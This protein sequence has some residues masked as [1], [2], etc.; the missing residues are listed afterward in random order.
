M[1]ADKTSSYPINSCEHR[2]HVVAATHSKV[3][4]LSLK[5]NLRNLGLTT[6]RIILT[7]P[8]ET[9]VDVVI[10]TGGSS[11]RFFFRISTELQ[12][13][14]MMYWV[15]ISYLYHCRCD[16]A[17]ATCQLMQTI[18]IMCL[19]PW[20]SRTCGRQQ[21]WPRWAIMS[22]IRYYQ[23]IHDTIDRGMCS[24]KTPTHPPKLK[25]VMSHPSDIHYHALS[26]HLLFI[27]LCYKQSMSA[28]IDLYRLSRI[29]GLILNNSS[30]IFIHSLIWQWM[31]DN[32][33][34]EE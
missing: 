23:F 14:E 5:S 1:H 24:A 29:G 2:S 12:N 28:G 19:L 21:R 13:A 31:V 22:V 7:S 11:W 15:C 18:L 10:L 9:L 26:D 4:R 30:I 33:P 16:L 17:S 25:T 8:I 32:L 34:R 27:S 6:Q 3:T 20:I